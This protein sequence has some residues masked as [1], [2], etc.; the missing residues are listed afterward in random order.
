MLN[1]FQG[2]HR[3]IRLIGSRAGEGKGPEIPALCVDARKEQIVDERHAIAALL[4]QLVVAPTCED[5]P[6]KTLYQSLFLF[7][8]VKKAAFE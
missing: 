7:I 1:K 6:A 8:R 3:H 2:L 5:I 4:E